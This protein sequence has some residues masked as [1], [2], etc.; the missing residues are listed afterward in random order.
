MALARQYRASVKRVYS[1]DTFVS[2]DSPLETS[3]FAHAPLGR[4]AVIRGLDNASI[5]PL[6]ELDRI[7]RIA[8]AQNIPLQVGA[9]NGGTDGSDFVRYGVVHAGLSWPGRY[10]HSPA[11]V[12]DLRDLHALERLIVAIAT[13][14]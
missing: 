4:G 9:T 5:T 10:S 14:P 12:L 2:S 1:V 13:A 8:R 3:R 11:E 6:D 7:L